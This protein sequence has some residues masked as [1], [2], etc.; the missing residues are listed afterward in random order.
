MKK[1]PSI[2][3]LFRRTVWV[4]GDEKLAPLA[5]RDRYLALVLDDGPCSWE[6]ALG[7]IL[8][9]RLIAVNI[10]VEHWLIVI[11]TWL[12]LVHSGD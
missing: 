4:L 12:I 7:V 10:V 2:T 1:H 6:T 11:K 5:D 8:L 3:Q 9:V